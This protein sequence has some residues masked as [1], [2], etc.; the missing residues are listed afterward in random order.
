MI[1]GWHFDREFPLNAI[2]IIIYLQNICFD[3][4]FNEILKYVA[5]KEKQLY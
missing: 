5:K 3:K 4:I 1:C 2:N